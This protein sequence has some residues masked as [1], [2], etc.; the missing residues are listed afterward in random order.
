[1]LEIFGIFQFWLSNLVD[2]HWNLSDMKYFFVK[3]VPYDLKDA[4]DIQPGWLFRPGRL[5]GTQKYRNTSKFATSR[6]QKSTSNYADFGKKIS[7]KAYIS[8]A[9]GT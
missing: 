4:Q 6:I 7:M 2:K 8:N 5:F 9:K 1:M 3:C